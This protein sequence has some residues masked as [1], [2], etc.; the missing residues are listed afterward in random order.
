MTAAIV[1]PLMTLLA[2]APEEGPGWKEAA[3]T[4]GITVYT[5]IPEG[6]DV[7]EVR[8]HGMID[9][10]PMAVW[11]AIRD[12]NNYKKTMPFTE[13]SRILEEKDEGKVIYFYSV[14][15]APLVSRRDYVIKLVD[16][17]KWEDGSGYLK[18]TWTSAADKIPAKD[19]MVRVK[20]NQGYWKL[21]PREGGAKTQ[22][23]YYVL[24]DPGGSLPK[25]IVN[26]AN[27]NAVPDVF[28]AVRKQATANTKK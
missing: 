9:A 17:S 10:P 12:Y 22:A 16:E 24:T 2:A 11:K 6:S 3:R 5:R 27:N 15:N 14:I 25:F 23:T 4:E 26:Q 18:V 21:E 20:V 28:K 13:E 1:L 19:G 7:G 8:A